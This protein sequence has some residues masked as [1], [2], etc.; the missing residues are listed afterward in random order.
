MEDPMR[1]LIALMLLVAGCAPHAMTVQHFGKVVQTTKVHSWQGDNFTIYTECPND[2]VDLNGNCPSGVQSYIQP[3][4]G[5]GERVA[6]AILQAGTYVPAGFLIRDGLRNMPASQMNNV[7]SADASGSSAS[8][9]SHSQSFANAY[10]SANVRQGWGH[11]GHR[12]W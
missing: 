3:S 7:N 12:G 10:S 2:I 8:A 1:Y 6:S 11:Y 9:V 5:W 4:P